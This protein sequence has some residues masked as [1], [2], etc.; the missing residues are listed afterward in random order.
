MI[1]A[2][3]FRGF[4]ELA[5]KLEKM[6]V[7]IAGPGVDRMVVSGARVFQRGVKER[8]PRLSAKNQGSNALEP[9]AMQNDIGV[10]LRHDALGEATATVRPSRKTAHV[11]SF[12]EYGHR[13]VTGG[14]SKV[15]GKG[16]G[17]QVGEVAAHPF[18]RP[19]YEA[20][21]REAEDAMIES[22]DGTIGA[23]NAE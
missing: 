6:G 21:Q 3:E 19:A 12:V 23:A 15:T 4:D 1:D 8:A 13:M 18:W 11:Q 20:E 9:G 16:P 22:M 7:E 17:R 10:H 5:L 14:Q 2:M